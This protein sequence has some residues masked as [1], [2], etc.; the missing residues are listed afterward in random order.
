MY[1]HSSRHCWYAQVRPGYIGR[2]HIEDAAA[3]ALVR[4]RFAKSRSE[5]LKSAWMKP[6]IE[7]RTGLFK[8]VYWCVARGTWYAQVG[9]KQLC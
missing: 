2:F 6:N 4:K 8:H 3:E 1:W 5:L 9:S 7:G